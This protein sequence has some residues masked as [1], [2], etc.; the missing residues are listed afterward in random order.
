MIK[1]LGTEPKR[2]HRSILKILALAFTILGIFLILTQV[3]NLGDLFFKAP[4]AAF[5]LITDGGLKNDNNRVNVLLLGIG[6]Q[7]HDG[8][9]LSDT[10]ILASV[11]KHGKDVALINIPRDIWVPDLKEKINAAYA[12]G[13]EKNSQGL[14]LA[15]DTVSKLFGIP[16]H[17]AIRVDFNGFTKAIDL[18]GGLD[19][20]VEN[21]F[22]DTRYPIPGKEDDT[23]GIQIEDKAGKTYF[24]DAT[25]SA[26]LLTEENNTFECR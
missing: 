18:V 11:E 6:G 14:A 12:I 24:K 5:N 20:D 4:K 22:T 26:Q 25:G 19:I 3:F 16:I 10:M 2:K 9:N 23:C 1:Q 21:S 15:E 17:Y 13:Q 8:P 7:G